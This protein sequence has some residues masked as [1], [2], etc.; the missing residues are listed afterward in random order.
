M[1]EKY[2]SDFSLLNYD[3]KCAFLREYSKTITYNDD[4]R[5]SFIKNQLYIKI[6]QFLTNEKENED[7]LLQKIYLMFLNNLISAGDS[8]EQVLIFNG[9]SEELEL[10]K[11][12][13]RKVNFDHKAQKFMLCIVYNLFLKNQK[14]CEKLSEKELCFLIEIISSLPFHKELKQVR[15]DK[16][17]S[18]INDWIHLIM[19]EILKSKKKYE[20]VGEK[21]ILEFLFQEKK[22]FLLILELSRDYI[23]MS[24]DKNYLQISQPNL[25][26]IMNLL[27]LNLKEIIAFINIQYEEKFISYEKYTLENTPIFVELL[28]LSDIISVFLLEDE[29]RETIQQGLYFPLSINE[30]NIAQIIHKLLT[31]T[32]EFYVMN[33]KR[34]KLMREEEKINLISLEEGN[35]FYSFQTNLI[36]FICNFCYKNKSLQ[37]YF[38]EN[39]LVFY[40]FMN[41]MK[42]DKCNPFKKEYT[43]LMIKSLV[44]GCKEIQNMIEILQPHEIDPMLKDYINKK[45]NVNVNSVENVMEHIKTKKA[46]KIKEEED[47]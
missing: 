35:V 28:C 17:L 45:G 22:F 12:C 19:K 46:E 36:K 13:F 31:S 15:E 11:C 37:A 9:L 4:I 42:L 38:S 29:Y 30:L 26:F 23:D 25:L 7:N 32:D 21:T 39:P 24:K 40:Y 44:E 6:I 1:E 20:K 41:H 3:K 2:N 47:D 8:S 5:K 43:V 14:N 33:F 10:L 16:D 18:E 34:N 27:K